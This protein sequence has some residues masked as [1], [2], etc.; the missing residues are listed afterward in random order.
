MDDPAPVG[1]LERAA[2]VDRDRDRPVELELAAGAVVERALQVAAADVL[3]D[4]ERHAAVL[5]RVEHADDVRVLAELA[6]RPRLA[7]GAGEHGLGDV[8]GVEDGDRDLAPGVLG[9]AGAEHALAPAAAEEALD[10]VAA[11]DQLRRRV[12]GAGA[13]A[14]GGRS[15]ASRRVP[16][17]SQKRASGRFG[18]PH[19]G[20]RMLG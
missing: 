6:H 5:A 4:D 19:A 1:V 11:G 15:G 14:L 20:Q 9:V 17:E 12:G 13:R 18:L 10:P 2:D 8:L 7:P 16:H 3:A